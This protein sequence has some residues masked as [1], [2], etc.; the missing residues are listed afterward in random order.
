[1]IMIIYCI[2]VVVDHCLMHFCKCLERKKKNQVKTFPRFSGLDCQFNAKALEKKWPLLEPTCNY[3]FQSRVSLSLSLI[4]LFC[5]L[6]NRGGLTLIS[7]TLP[8]SVRG[9][10]RSKHKL[11]RTHHMTALFFLNYYYYLLSLLSLAFF[12]FDNS[13]VPHRAF[14]NQGGS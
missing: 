12:F 9:P 1:M 13:S 2:I 4:N 5:W 10:G 6:D 7:L 8:C 14:V 11:L 3:M